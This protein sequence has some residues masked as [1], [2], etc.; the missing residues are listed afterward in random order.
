MLQQHFEKFKDSVQNSI[1]SIQQA[2]NI[3]CNV[4]S[5]IPSTLDLQKSIKSGWL[6]RLGNVLKVWSKKWFVLK[7]DYLL[8]YSSEET[9]KQPLGFVYIPGSNIIGVEGK[10]NDPE[11]YIIEIWQGTNFV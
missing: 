7:G 8:F 11:K 2:V 5:F 3:N 10:Y 9:S 6:K 4:P 1:S